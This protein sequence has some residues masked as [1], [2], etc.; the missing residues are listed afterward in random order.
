[1]KTETG[2][3]IELSV[4]T[5]DF[6]HMPLLPLDRILVG[7][8]VTMVFGVHEGRIYI[9]L[10]DAERITP[11]LD[12]YSLLLKRYKVPTSIISQT[13]HGDAECGIVFLSGD[14]IEQEN[15][16]YRIIGLVDRGWFLVKEEATGQES[17][18]CSTPCGIA[19]AEI[20]H[21]PSFFT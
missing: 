1:M 8:K 3:L 21:R 6:L 13:L 17:I 9:Q 15:S 11:L 2:K 18:R 19:A 14:V 10:E 16:D 5:S 7:G 4:H 12:D 20:V